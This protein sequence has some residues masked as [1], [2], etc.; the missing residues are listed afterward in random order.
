MSAISAPH[1]KSVTNPGGGSNNLWGP[2][3]G[4]AKEQLGP[5]R[6]EVHC[7]VGP[8]GNRGELCLVAG[9][10]AVNHVV[11]LPAHGDGEVGDA[12]G[13]GDSLEALGLDVLALEETKCLSLQIV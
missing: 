2:R 5:V 12:V 13:V 10:A 1:L 11:V 8:L 6:L 7:E 3:L 4:P 9:L